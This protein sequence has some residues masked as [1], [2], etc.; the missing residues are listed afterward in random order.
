MYSVVASPVASILASTGAATAAA[1]TTLAIRHS[2]TGARLR[3][4]VRHQIK[5]RLPAVATRDELVRA[6]GTEE[7][8]RERRSERT[9]L[10][11]R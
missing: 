2:P 5:A 6:G 9:V 8:S 1:A 11:S 7:S 3:S 4:A 10:T